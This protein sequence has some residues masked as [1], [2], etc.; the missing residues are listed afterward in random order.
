MTKGVK[1]CIAVIAVVFIIALIASLVLFQDSDSQY[2]SIVQD[3]QVLYNISLDSD[4]RTIRIEDKDGG[5]NI[6]E[7]SDGKIRISEADCPDKTCVNTGF[8]SGDMPIVC[9]PHKLVI[10]YT[11]EN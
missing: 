9:L 1:I 7:I 6:V 10:K 11:D 2:V 5:Y 4:D 8:L 3:N